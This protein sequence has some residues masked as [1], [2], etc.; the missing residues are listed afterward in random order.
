MYEMSAKAAA[1]LY[2]LVRQAEIRCWVMGGWG[3]DA[4]L[5][6]QTRPHHDLDLLV[7]AEDLP[8]FHEVMTNAGFV[9]RYLWD[10]ENEWITLAGADWP[11]AFV[12][13]DV[14]GQELDVHAVGVAG[15]RAVPRCHVPWSFPDGALM[16][17]GVIDG[18]IVNCLSVEAQFAA[19]TGYELPEAHTKDVQALSRL[20]NRPV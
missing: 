10:D 16:G 12:M 3:V 18:A 19:H 15:G 4:L 6:V 17:T 7:L 2:R 5:G 1:S 9:R 13:S 8:R 14:S 11:T 20:R